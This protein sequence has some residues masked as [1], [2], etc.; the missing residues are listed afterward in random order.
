MKLIVLAIVCLLFSDQEHMKQKQIE[1]NQMKVTWMHKSGRVHFSMEAPTEG[2][3]TIG[4]NTG[5]G[6]AGAYLLMGRI[7]SG[8]SEIVEHYTSSPGNYAPI[9]DYGIPVQVKDVKGIQSQGKTK[10]TFSLPHSPISK[11][12]RSLEPGR[13]YDLIIAYSTS[14]NFQ[15]HSR[16]RTSIKIKL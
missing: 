7:V 6:M 15:H 9:G 5:Q 10:L 1:K 14:D 11:Y 4:M 13:E 16:M 8:K 12:H 3:V 2:W